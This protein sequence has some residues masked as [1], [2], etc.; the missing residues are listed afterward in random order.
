M[1]GAHAGLPAITGRKILQACSNKMRALSTAFPRKR[2][3]RTSLT[4]LA[5][6]K[7]PSRTG[8]PRNSWSKAGALPGVSAGEVAKSAALMDAPR[9][10][11]VASKTPGP[12]LAR[13]RTRGRPSRHNSK[14]WRQNPVRK[15]SPQAGRPR[16]RISQPMNTAFPDSS[17]RVFQ[18]ERAPSKKIA[19]GGSHSMT[20]PA[21]TRTVCIWLDTRPSLR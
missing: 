18:C 6:A 5:E 13:S 10:P 9:S 16:H 11:Q 17:M 7:V 19:S 8:R 20:P 14:C 3:T 15:R 4:T 21:A 12:S 2:N 1:R